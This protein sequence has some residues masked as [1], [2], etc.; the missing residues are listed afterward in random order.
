MCRVSISVQVASRVSQLPLRGAA[1][2][3]QGQNRPSKHQKVSL[4]PLLVG[5]ING[6]DPI[7]TYQPGC[8]CGD[9]RVVV[10]GLGALRHGR[11]GRLSQLYGANLQFGLRPELI[12]CIG[13]HSRSHGRARRNPALGSFDRDR[14]A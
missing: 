9:V 1:V 8:P 3:N 13:L 4:T 2:S 14:Q 10:L 5:F 11:S 6:I 12:G 7:R